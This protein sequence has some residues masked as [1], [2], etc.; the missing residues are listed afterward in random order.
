MIQRSVVASSF[1]PSQHSLSST[2]AMSYIA[3]YFVLTVTS[4]RLGKDYPARPASRAIEY[5]TYVFF[6]MNKRFNMCGVR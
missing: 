6:T 3:L 5:Y 2:L 4:G 1:C